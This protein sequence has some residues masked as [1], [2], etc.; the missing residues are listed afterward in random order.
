ML[1][2]G[3]FRPNLLEAKGCTYCLDEQAPSCFCKAETK[4][5]LYDNL[6]TVLSVWVSD[7]VARCRRAKNCSQVTRK[8]KRFLCVTYFRKTHGIYHDIRQ[9]SEFSIWW[10][11]VNIWRIA[12]KSRSF[13]GILKTSM[14]HWHSCFKVTLRSK[15]YPSRVFL[16]SH[17]SLVFTCL[18]NSLFGEACDKARFSGGISKCISI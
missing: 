11:Y 3:L 17:C 14:W 15:K 12:L 9:T 16:W 10:R 18:G 7:I 6:Q 8:P 4:T 13:E 5:N 2:E 1:F